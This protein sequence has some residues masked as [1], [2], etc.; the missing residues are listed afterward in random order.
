MGWHDEAEGDQSRGDPSTAASWTRRKF[1]LSAASSTGWML[2]GCGSGSDTEGNGDSPPLDASSPP[3][4]A[5][6]VPVGATRQDAAP[7]PHLPPNVTWMYFKGNG[8]ERGRNGD[9]DRLPDLQR[10]FYIPTMES[11]TDML[12]W[13]AGFSVC[14]QLVPVRQAAYY[15]T[16]FYAA[17]QDTDFSDLRDDN[18]YV[19]CHPYPHSA[20][21]QD[22]DD[23]RLHKWEISIDGSDKVTD[24]VQYGELH[25]QAFR[26]APVDGSGRS[27]L[28]FF[29]NVSGS[30][31]SA[32][33]VNHYT[34]SGRYAGAPA[35]PYK[36][37]VFGNAPWWRAHQHERLSGFVR[38]IKV[39]AGELSPEDLLAESLSDELATAAGASRIWWGKISPQT[40]DDLTSDF[41]SPG[42]QRRVAAW[43]DD[44]RC[45]IVAN[46]ALAQH[47]AFVNAT[48]IGNL[49]HMERG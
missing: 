25:T 4:D 20:L 49:L 45:E 17:S 21:G 29:P 15:T 2:L 44:S 39:F 47:H 41:V 48:T 36:A 19:G 24:L 3:P 9:Y 8:H 43:I 14:W 46:W 35:H 28:S 16:F 7:A 40:P 13:A 1:V 26:C 18:G 33:S 11:G 6:S 23:F 31:V 38:R 10:Y 42:D 37:M 22:G 5:G 12:P 32:Q 34:H 30:N 27:D